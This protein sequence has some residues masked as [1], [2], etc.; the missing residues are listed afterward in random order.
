MTNADTAS[1]PQP[2]EGQG[3]R[4]DLP[5][6]LAYL[7]CAYMSPQPRSVTSAGERALRA[8]RIPTSIGPRD[9]F[10]P[11]ERIRD[12]FARLVGGDA[13]G[14]AVVPGVSS[15]VAVAAANLRVRPGE[16]ILRLA[17]Q[18]P[19][20][21]YAWR[22]LADE[23]GA[24]VD[25][26]PA[27]GEGDWTGPVLDRLDDD[28]AVV[29]VPGCHWT[30]GRRL[31]LERVGRA[32]RRA[33]A[34][35]VV[36]ASQS[37]GAAP[38]DVQRV[39]PDFLITVVYK[40]LFGPYGMGLMW[41]APEHRDGRPLEEGWAVRRGA[42]DFNRLVDYTDEYAPG[43]RRFDMG[44]RCAFIH[45]AMAEAA[46]D[47]VLEWGVERIAATTGRLLAR[48]DDQLADV[49]VGVLPA[50]DR[51]AHMTGLRLPPHVDRERLRAGL[52]DAR[53]AVSARADAVRVSPHVYNTPGDVDRLCEVLA[54]VV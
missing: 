35:L 20:N 43:A 30:D 39:R 51:V 15:G 6:G 37:L 19:S 42:E 50:R 45:V 47:R 31:D 44:E 9:F 26:V 5:D 48:L 13:D 41:V 40:W 18:F 12:R 8:R 34:A 16:R 29:A 38:L 11:V 24:A 54:A 3:E 27:P 22:R 46:L 17:E 7:N 21:V 49:G 14:V 1:A 4:F 32:A 23:T 33:G 2:L 25:A 10:E 36:D 52:D 28:V 53:V